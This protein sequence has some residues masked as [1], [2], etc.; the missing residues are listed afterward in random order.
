[1][2]G[3]SNHEETDSKLDNH[4]GHNGTVFR[5]ACLFDNAEVEVREGRRARLLAGHD[6]AVP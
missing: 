1:M 4:D 3:G 5:D 2:K 6:K